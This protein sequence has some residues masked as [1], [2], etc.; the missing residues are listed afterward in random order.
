MPYYKREETVVLESLV[1]RLAQELQQ[2]QTPLPDMATITGDQPAIIEETSHMGRIGVT[3]IWD[4]WKDLSGEKRGQVIMKAYERALGI[5]Y[6]R[7][8][9][10]AMGL[11]SAQKLLLD[12]RAES[13]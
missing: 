7:R 10:L 1:D 8:I 11:T 4:E 3:V 9:G 2:P 6:V 13:A 12:D 5:E